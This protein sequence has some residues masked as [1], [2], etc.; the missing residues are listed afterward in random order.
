M[1]YSSIIS[2]PLFSFFVMVLLTAFSGFRNIDNNEQEIVC[3]KAL[4]TVSLSNC[5]SSV[6][7]LNQGSTCSVA[8]AQFGKN[9]GQ[10]GLR[11]NVCDLV[12]SFFCCAQLAVDPTPCPGQNSFDF[13]DFSGVSQFN[14]PATIYAIFCKSEI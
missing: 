7:S 5:S 6:V 8:V 9:V 13:I 3:Y 1:K 12:E 11:G 4:S 14:K 10:L 2:I